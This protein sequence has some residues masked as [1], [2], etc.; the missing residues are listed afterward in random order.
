MTLLAKVRGDFL[1]EVKFELTL[2]VEQDV[3]WQNWKERAFQEA[4]CLGQHPRFREPQGR[5][6]GA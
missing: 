6:N 5:E 4:T 2:K 3:T 1:Q